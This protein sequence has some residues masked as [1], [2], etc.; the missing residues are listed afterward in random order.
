MDNTIS[1]ESIAMF[2]EK[3]AKEQENNINKKKTNSIRKA[4]EAID[5]F[6]MN[7]STSFTFT[8]GE[9]NAYMG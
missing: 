3:T 9:L 8:I 4:R 7:E 2:V 6:N 1:L 5:N